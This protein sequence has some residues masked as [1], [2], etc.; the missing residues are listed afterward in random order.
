MFDGS[1]GEEEEEETLET[2]SG[3]GNFIIVDNLPVVAS[4]KYEK[5]EGAIRKIFGQIDII[6]QNGL[7]MTKDESGKTKAML[8]LSTALLRYLSEV[9]YFV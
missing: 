9:F 1:D 8:S 7:L 2:E 3:F 5:L 4:E 6:T